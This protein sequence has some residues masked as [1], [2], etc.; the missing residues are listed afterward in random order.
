MPIRDAVEDDLDQILQLINDLAAYEKAA[1]DEV[2]A[3]REGLRSALFTDH[4]KVF[5]LIAETDDR[6]VAGFALWFYNFST[7]EGVHGVY[8]EDLFVRPDFRGHGFGSALL[9]R[10]ARIAAD[11]GCARMEWVVLNW[12]TPAIAV[13]Q[14]IG[15]KPLDDW[16]T[17]RL[18][19][20]ALTG[21][22]ALDGT[23]TGVET[24]A[25]GTK[26]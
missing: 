23:K 3:T 21:L 7:W 9:R 24:T 12:N 11:N 22:A 20:D 16:T 17:Y 5:C 15:A 19:G 14:G 2:K 4:P 8:L 25:E 1:P 18:T 10:L 13:Y 26:S 6:Q